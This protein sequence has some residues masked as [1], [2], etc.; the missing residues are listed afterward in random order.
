MKTHQ[1]STA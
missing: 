1:A